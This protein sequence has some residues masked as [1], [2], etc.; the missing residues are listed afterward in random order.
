MRPQQFVDSMTAA[1]ET[2]S[3]KEI[4][5]VALRR[6]SQEWHAPHLGRHDRD[7]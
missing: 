3:A 1:L 5:A 2:P 4:A 6:T 7:S